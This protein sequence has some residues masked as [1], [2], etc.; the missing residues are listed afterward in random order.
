MTRTLQAIYEDGVLRPL[1]DPGLEEH[2]RV[3]L[4]IRTE[5]LS[6]VS[7]A[8]EGWRRVYDGLSEGDVEEVEALALD[9]GRFFRP[10]P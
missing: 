10:E 2:Q 3:F 6:T 1:E 4:E 7:S 5:P 8:L 9:R